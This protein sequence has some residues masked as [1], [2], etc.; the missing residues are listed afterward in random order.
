[1]TYVVVLESSFMLLLYERINIYIL[2]LLPKDRI[3]TNKLV[4]G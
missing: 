4:K 3:R 1:M 2:G